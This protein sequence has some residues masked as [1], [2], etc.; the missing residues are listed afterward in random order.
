M[1]LRHAVKTAQ[2]PGLTRDLPYGPEDLR[3]VATRTP[4]ELYA[5]MLKL[6]PQRA[7]PGSLWGGANKP[8]PHR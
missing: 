4:E 6:Y 3:W 5:E 8:W 1:G 7:N 2:L